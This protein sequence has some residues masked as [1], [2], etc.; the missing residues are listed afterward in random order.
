MSVAP[1]R[2]DIP[3][4]QKVAITAL[5]GVMFAVSAV[6]AFFAWHGIEGAEDPR[7]SAIGFMAMASFFALIGAMIGL[8]GSAFSVGRHLRRV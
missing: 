5:A 8:A 1:E 2:F 6:A 4:A 3:R 7:A